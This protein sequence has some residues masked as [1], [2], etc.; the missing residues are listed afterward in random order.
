MKRNDYIFALCANLF[1]TIIC[2]TVASIALTHNSYIV[3]IPNLA[4]TAFTAICGVFDAYHA[5]TTKD[6][7]DIL[8]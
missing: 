4:C 1:L 3:A 2:G 7:T 5:I 8:K 6:T